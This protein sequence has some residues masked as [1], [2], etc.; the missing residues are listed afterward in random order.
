[1]SEAE[2]RQLCN[3]A[4]AA[5]TRGDAATAVTLARQA[6]RHIPLD[7][8][9][10]QIVGAAALA[11]GDFRTAKQ[12]LLRAKG[13]APNQPYVH[14]TLGLALQGAGELNSARA[15]F[16]RAGELGFAGAW[17][18]LGGLETEAG[19]TAAAAAAYARAVA[20]QPND[21]TAHAA[22][23]LI[24]E[25]RHDAAAA[26]RH[27]RAALDIDPMNSIARLALAQVLVRS[28]A[29]A[30]AEAEAL[31]ATG[32]KNSKGNRS[33]A[34][35]LVGEARDQLGRPR[36]AFA[37][38][39]EAN[40]LMAE[41]D[42]GLRTARHL[43]QH[44]AGVAR[45]LD[46]A[47]RT[48][49]TAREVTS[50]SGRAPVFLIG[51]PRSGTT[52]L[53]Q[54]L[55]SHSAFVSIEEMDLFAGAMGDLLRN[56]TRL[57]GLTAIG[58]EEVL[59]LRAA[60][61]RAAEA[62]APDCRE[63]T[64][65]DKLPLNLIFL[66]LIHFVFPDAKVILA[67]RDPRD[68]VLSSFQQRFTV[69]AA[70]VQTLELPSAAAYYDLTMRVF[71]ACKDRLGKRLLVVRYEDIVADL[72]V[73]AQRLA[74]FLGVAFEPAMLTFSETALARNITTPS[75]R[76]VIEP[77]YERAIGKWRAYAEEMAPVLP[78]LNEWARRWG[79]PI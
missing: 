41:L 71:E 37:A 61:W 12:H 54:I 15:A 49:T 30:A 25:R 2:G 16:T 64:L 34:W 3:A 62:Q 43:P 14:N 9:A 11:A 48:R 27:A 17:R 56:E 77:I 60:Y 68:C 31:A 70:M 24:L 57:A 55:S 1:M 58:A 18:N 10:N 52:L 65:I 72:E 39:T 53:D 67:L 32:E 26:E 63:R 7:A 44:P 45:M 40:R 79:Y 59:S 42:D 78:L 74:S 75:A 28:K 4:V 19:D 46:L 47:D 76:Q 36:E 13:S 23:A 21:A 6:L 29:F 51:F 33:L 5:H 35:G 69:N 38:F 22:L 8:R 66:P 50:V 73:Q 20:L